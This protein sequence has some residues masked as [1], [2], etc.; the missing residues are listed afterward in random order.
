MKLLC[1]ITPSAPPRYQSHRQPEWSTSAIR[2]QS[3]LIHVWAFVKMCHALDSLY[4]WEFFNN[5]GYEWSVVRGLRP[6][7]WSIWLYSLTRVAALVAVILNM[8]GIN[9]TSPLNCQVWLIFQL[10]FGYLAFAVASLLIVLRIIAIWNK[11]RGV[12]AVA[13]GIWVINIGFLIQ[14]IARLRATR[15]T[16]IRELQICVISDTERS[17]PNIIVTL[18]T[19][20]VLLVIMLIGLIRF[21]QCGGGT[22]GLGRLLWKQGVIWLF[23]ASIAEVPPTVFICLNL[24]Y[25]FNLMFQVPSLTIMS[26]AATR[27]YRALTDYSESTNGVQVSLQTSDLETPRMRVTSLISSPVEV[28]MHTTFE[29]YPLSQTSQPSHGS[30]TVVDDPGQPYDKPDRLSH[31]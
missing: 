7:R 16:Y 1:G 22:F 17:K 3:W 18:I 5:L 21:R 23:L 4:L 26:I 12:V 20:V 14:G 25:P 10:V 19:D 31:A 29:Q 30:S 9:V 8:V 11:H 6:Y 2:T 24:N 15:T 13:T 27:I 28:A